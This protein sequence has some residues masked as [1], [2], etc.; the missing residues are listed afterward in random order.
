M[1]VGVI[2]SGS[3]GPDLAYGFLSAIA[4]SGGTVLLHDI[5]KEALDAGVARIGK[6][7][8]KAIAR[9]KLSAKD[10]AAMRQHLVPTLELEQLAGCEYVLEAATEHLETKRA[11]LRNLER[12]VSKD[13]LVG[14]ATSGLPRARI[15]EGVQH[16]GRCFVNHPFYPAWRAPRRTSAPPPRSSSRRCR[17]RRSRRRP[18]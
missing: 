8:E 6:Y 17:R 10:A 15:V 1:N 14:F 18:R 5:R 11:I 2:G 12:V 7:M 13:C 16:P 9:G 3:I 4:R